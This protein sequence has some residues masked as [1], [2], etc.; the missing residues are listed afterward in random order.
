MYVT[1]LSTT[2]QKPIP[3]V[4]LATAHLL[5]IRI[6]ISSTLSSTSHQQLDNIS[7][8]SRQHH[9]QHL[10]NISSTLASRQLHGLISLPAKCEWV[11]CA[12]VWKSLGTEQDG[13]P[14]AEAEGWKCGCAD[15]GR[16]PTWARRCRWPWIRWSPGHGIRSHI[17]RNAVQ[18]RSLIVNYFVNVI[19][20]I[21]TQFF[22]NCQQN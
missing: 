17:W 4:H 12:V 14:P 1:D 6:S 19:K 11:I 16:T 7:S 20:F 18:C 15:R 8:T 9:Q 21:F 2:W 13:C 10:I 3:I 22:K 5:I